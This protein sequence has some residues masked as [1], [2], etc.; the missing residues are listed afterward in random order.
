MGINLLPST[1]SRLRSMRTQIGAQRL[2][3]NYTLSTTT[4]T[5]NSSIAELQSDAGTKSTRYDHNPAAL[6]DCASKDQSH[7]GSSCIVTDFG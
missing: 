1:K 5:R 2:T 7:A 6:L 3:V 4:Q